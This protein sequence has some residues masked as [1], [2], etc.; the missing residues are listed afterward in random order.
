MSLN[1]SRKGPEPLFVP[2]FKRIRLNEK[3]LCPRRENGIHKLQI[4]GAEGLG[5]DLLSARETAPDIVDPD[6]KHDVIG[7]FVHNVLFHPLQKLRRAVAV[8]AAVD[9]LKCGIR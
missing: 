8:H 5:R 7:I 9:K 3:E 1:R 2:H 4:V 6:F